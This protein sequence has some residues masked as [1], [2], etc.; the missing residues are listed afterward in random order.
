MKY[1][2]WKA[3]ARVQ[4]FGGRVEIEFASGDKVDGRKPGS[5]NQKPLGYKSCTFTPQNTIPVG[6]DVCKDQTLWAR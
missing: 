1:Q 5:Q 4:E 2:Q 3:V 6:H